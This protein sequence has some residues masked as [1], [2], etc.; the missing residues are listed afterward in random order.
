MS[1]PHEVRASV[2]VTQEQHF[3]GDLPLAAMPRLSEALADDAQSVSVD[4]MADT[5][6]GWPRLHGSLS[7]TLQ[8]QCLR[9]D[10]VYAWPLN[11]QLDLRLVESEADEDSDSIGSADPYWA[12]ADRLPLRELVEEEV[13]LALP[14]LPR[15]ETCENAV[16]AALPAP[17]VEPV[18]KR[19]N[20][21]AALKQQLKAKQD[22]GSGPTE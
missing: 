15:C 14:M 9:C 2:A 21:F 1:I 4:L 18:A 13:L 11:A 8:L 3:C 17:G 22:Q 7:G 20:P 6:S 19:E 16:L 10:R 12:R 5:R